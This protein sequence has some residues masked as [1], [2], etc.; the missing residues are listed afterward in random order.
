M[1]HSSTA[2]FSASEWPA[3][4]AIATRLAGPNDRDNNGRDGRVRPGLDR[5]I[6][7]AG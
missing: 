2:Y 6:A 1:A 7:A 5:R 3:G 4:R